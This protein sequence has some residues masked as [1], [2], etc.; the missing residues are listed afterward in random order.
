MVY[1]FLDHTADVKFIAEGKTIEEAFSESAYALKEVICGK[2]EIL[3]KIEKE[4]EIKAED[5]EGLLYRFLEEFL[6]L[7]DSEDFLLS[8]INSIIIDK[9]ELILNARIIGDKAE[10]YNFT[11]D[12][13]A[14][15]YSQI[16]VNKTNEEFSCQVVLD[17]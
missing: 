6:L 13:K 4:I 1:K 7:L 14:V 10:N 16:K 8:K 5:F 9:K 15:T 11:N 12:V 3:E 2:I 17:V